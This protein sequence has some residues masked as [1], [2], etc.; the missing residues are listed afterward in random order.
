MPHLIL[1]HDL[2]TTGNKAT[3]YDAEGRLLGSA[4]HPY[5]TDYPQPRWAE[6]NPQDW[7][8]AI[9]TSTRRLLART[10]TPAS[11]IA[12]I[13]FS[14]QMMG[15]VAL[16]RDARPLRPAIIWADQRATDQT[17]ALGARIPF[18][19]IYRITGH[20]LSPAYSVEKILWLRDHQPD[21][22]HRAYK[23]THAKDAIVARLTGAFVTDPSDASGMNLYDL[24]T[25][26]WSPEILEATDLDPAQLPE[27]RPSASVVGTVLPSV[28]AEAGVPAGTP[29]VIGGGDG[30]CAAA[31]AGVV[32]PGSA[33]NYIGASS[34]IALATPAPIFDPDYTTFT[35]AHI[36]PDLFMPDGTMQTAGAAYQWTRD[37][38]CPQAIT[39]AATL[40]LNP[41]DLLNAQAAQSPPGANGLLFL[42]YLLGE[43][44][45]HWDPLARGAFIGLTIRH[46]RADLI[47][48][49]LEGVA[50]NLRLILQAFQAQGA[51]PDAMRL[52]GGG[53]RSPLWNQILADIYQLPVHRLSLLQ[54]ATSMGAALAGGLA[55]GL[56]PDA[57]VALAMNPIAAT[58]EPNA[59]THAL[60]TEL[61]SLFVATYRALAPLYPRL[62]D[63]PST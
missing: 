31:G 20:R 36:L 9:C 60:Y 11:D 13:T 56:Y 34:W 17:E 42:P 3:L 14:G 43:R 12:C 46:T 35:F 55:L 62:A 6:Q 32:A 57:S 47:R 24:S 41:Y 23:F 27:I 61:T 40:D 8:D 39:A 25:G 2:G 59:K 38:L 54:E 48:A 16:D 51:Q 52:I 10:N 50:L 5:D 19:D 21:L 22:F 4:F 49:V 29:V 44:S 1:A 45:P 30:A 63:L 7:W 33:Y 37:Q 15:C 28:A 18:A 53:A 58:L 26:Y